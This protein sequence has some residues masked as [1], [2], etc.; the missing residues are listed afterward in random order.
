[1]VGSRTAVLN[2]NRARI[3]LQ[4]DKVER[5]DPRGERASQEPGVPEEVFY[6]DLIHPTKFGYQVQRRSKD[7]ER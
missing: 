3:G 4:I 7:F 6:H 5:P 1:M 2:I